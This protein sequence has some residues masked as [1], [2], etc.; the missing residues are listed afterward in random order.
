MECC[1]LEVEKERNASVILELQ[2][3]K[4]ELEHD[5]SEYLCS[6]K[7]RDIA[8]ENTV[9]ALAAYLALNETVLKTE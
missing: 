1:S 9:D 8:L 4:R 5:I 6:I 2:A 7:L 3:I